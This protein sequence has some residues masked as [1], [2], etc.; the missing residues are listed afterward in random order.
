MVRA[1]DISVRN[2]ASSAGEQAN[3]LAL[4]LQRNSNF[5]LDDFT[6]TGTA[7][8]T[9]EPTPLLMLVTAALAGIL[10]MR[11]GAPEQAVSR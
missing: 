10:L 2:R 6:F 11:R 8:A 3:A 7:A 9:P 5:V 4:A 1:H